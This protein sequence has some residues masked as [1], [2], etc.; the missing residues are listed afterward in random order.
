[1]ESSA[2][3]V[4]ASSATESPTATT[5][6]A[7]STT[8]SSSAKGGSGHVWCWLEVLLRCLISRRR[9]L[10]ALPALE[11]LHVSRTRRDR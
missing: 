11:V 1:M 8:E 9:H 6:S 4:E 2:T 7:P 3:T 10:S 5:E